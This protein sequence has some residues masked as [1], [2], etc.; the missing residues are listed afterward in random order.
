MKL[1]IIDYGIGNVKSL[2]R[3]LRKVGADVEISGDAAKIKAADGLILPGVG[4]FEAA[5]ARLLPI[6][7]LVLE[8]TQAGKPMLGICLGLQILYS[9]SEEGGDFQGLDV[10]KGNVR[11]FP[12]MDLKVPHMG[13]N[14]LNIK[15]PDHPLY[16][17]LPDNPYVYF[18]HSY[19]GDAEN[20]EDI[21]TTTDYG[22][23]FPSSVAKGSILAT[24]F[25]PEKSGEV[26]LQ[27]LKNF[28][29]IVK[30]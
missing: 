5:I 25:H 19:Y 29:G 4:A 1:V 28:M 20:K 12:K 11:H 15:Q 26:G 30:K 6:A 24:Q 18:V 9:R 10:I 23:E 14:S 17:N 22:I 2:E 16:Q 21:L 3:S 27:I 8:E 7:P 13:W